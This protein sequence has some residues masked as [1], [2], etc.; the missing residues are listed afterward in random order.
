MDKRGEGEGHEVVDKLKTYALGLLA[1]VVGLLV[2][3]LRAKG[4]ALHKAQIDLLLLKFGNTDDADQ[5]STDAAMK[6]YNKAAK[7]YWD[8]KESDGK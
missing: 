1:G 4:Q 7:E 3:L 6:A 8:A 5:K 2:W